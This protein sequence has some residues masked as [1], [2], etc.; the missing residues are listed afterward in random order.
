MKAW[1]FLC[2]AVLAAVILTACG[3]EPDGPFEWPESIDGERSPFYGETLT[4]GVWH[5]LNMWESLSNAIELRNPGVTIEIVD[6][7]GGAVDYDIEAVREEMSLLLMGGNAPVLM[8]AALVDYLNPATRPLFADWLPVMEADPSFNE[9]DWFMNVFYSITKDGRLLGLPMTFD[10]MQGNSYFAFNAS[11]PGLAEEWAG[12]QGI[13]WQELI[14][15]YDRVSPNLASPMYLS[16]NFDVLIAV[17]CAIYDF[18]DWETGR[19]EF[20]TPEFIALITRARELTSPLRVFGGTPIGWNPDRYY[21]ANIA[22]L[23]ERYMFRRVWTIHYDAFGIFHEAPPFGHPIPWTNRQGELMVL[24]NVT[25]ALNAGATNAEQ[26]L[27]FELLRTL[28]E[29]PAEGPRYY[30]IMR[31][32]SE[33]FGF[34]SSPHRTGTEFIMLIQ[35]NWIMQSFRD[36]YGV[37]ADGWPLAFDAMIAR[38]AATKSMPMRDRRFGPFAVRDAVR[39]ILEQFHEGLI[40]AEQA[41]NDLQ[42]RVTLIIME[43]D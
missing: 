8:D 6:I 31:G 39:E 28:L 19:V 11:V 27:A 32:F 9:D 14:E 41:A 3:N 24:P 4:V 25:F 33:W 42:N 2:A 40:T 38:D 34:F 13:S 30:R 5:S 1:S 35:P 17:E 10:A 16:R 7:S 43:M 22:E 12:R 20:N 37:P 36:I 29:I 21:R 26:A 18:L 15:I 23:A